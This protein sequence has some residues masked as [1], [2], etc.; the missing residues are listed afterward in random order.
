MKKVWNIGIITPAS[1]VKG[2]APLS[3]LVDILSSLSN[4]VYVI[5]ADGKVISKDTI[6]IESEIKRKRANMVSRVINYIYMQLRISYTSLRL[7]R[8]TDLWIFYSGEGLI[9]P[10]LVIKLFKKRLILIVAG[11]LEKEGEV[12]KDGSFK[13][14]NFIANISYELSNNVILYSKTLIKDWNLEKYRDKILIAH[15]HFVNYNKFKIEKKI[16]ERDNLVGYVGRL[17][18]E[19]GVLNFVEAIPNILEGTDKIKFLIAGDGTLYNKIKIYL[20][21]NNLNEKVKLTGW[22][23]HDKLPDYLNELKL[24]ILPSYNEGLPNLMIEGMA[25]GTPVLATPVGAIPDVIKDSKTGFIME[26]NSPECI[27]ENVMRTLEHPDL[28]EIV[29]NAREL[30]ETKFTYEAAVDGHR[31]I[32]E[33]I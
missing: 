24:V 5:T 22:I 9:F 7:L 21:E 29:K 19:K 23:P 6:E 27:A 4:N 25:C 32:L 30:V 15:K 18:E 8:M 26:N 12:K 28:E 31:K 20:N 10:L 3:N 16:N 11:S 33:N 2:N 17:S 13:I 1:N 14:L